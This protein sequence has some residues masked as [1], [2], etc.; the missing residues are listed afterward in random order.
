MRARAHRGGGIEKVK[1]EDWMV[2]AEG[3]GGG[4]HRYKEEKGEEKGE[5]KK[6]RDA[7]ENEKS[8]V[9]LDHASIYPH[10]RF[11]RRTTPLFPPPSS[12]TAYEALARGELH[13]S[14]SYYTP[15][16]ASPTYPLSEGRRRRHRTLLPPN[17]LPSVCYNLLLL[18][19]QG[20]PYSRVHCMSPRMRVLLLTLCIRK[21]LCVR[22]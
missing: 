20:Q 13:N 22:T 7:R 3:S 17:T 9:A 4:T 21:N 1:V 18:P 11:S 10:L 15:T 12:W 16:A 8:K 2:V 5:G 14:W 6:E 19:Y